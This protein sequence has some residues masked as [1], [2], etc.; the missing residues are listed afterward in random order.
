M[1]L[2]KFIT[3]TKND[4]F[5]QIIILTQS[6][7]YRAN[8]YEWWILFPPVYT[9]KSPTGYFICIETGYNNILAWRYLNLF[10]LLNSMELLD[11]PT[12]YSIQWTHEIFKKTTN[13]DILNVFL[14][15]RTLIV[16]D[17][18]LFRLFK[19]LSVTELIG[20]TVIDYI[21]LKEK[22]FEIWWD[23]KANGI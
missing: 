7:C 16:F 21:F 1:Y 6:K 10:F 2:L 23:I 5:Y 13:K 8:D 11:M 14:Y 3:K 17:V 19:I 4:V 18:N 22:A 20:Q 9:W 12:M 15:R